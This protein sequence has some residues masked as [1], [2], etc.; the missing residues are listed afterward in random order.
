MLRPI[1]ICFTIRKHATSPQTLSILSSNHSFA[2]LS[3][4]KGL[5]FYLVPFLRQKLMFST[6]WR[7]EMNVTLT[8]LE[9]LADL[10]KLDARFIGRSINTFGFLMW[11]S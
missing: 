2:D 8:A 6:E 9:L 4:T 3:T 1:G 10:A 11:Q 7:S 5:F